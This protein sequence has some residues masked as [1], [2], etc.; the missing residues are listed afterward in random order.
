MNVE[1][2]RE[3]LEE[4]RDVCSQ[5]DA[6][7]DY[8]NY[9]G[10]PALRERMY[11]LEPTAK[12]VLAALDP[13]LADFEIDNIG[14]AA[15]ARDRA[16]KGLGLLADADEIERNLRP[17][18]PSLPADELH[19][20][21]W[22]AARTFWDAGQ[23]AVAVEQAAKSVTAHTQQKTGMSLADDDLMAQAWSD[24]PPKRD[25]PRLRFEGDRESPTWR[26]R[27]KGA[28]FLALGCYAGIRNIAAHAVSPD[29]SPQVALEALAAFSIV[30][31]WV[32]EASVVAAD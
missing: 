5:Y 16:I 19:P 12:K 9:S 3:R 32:D 15:T 26:S 18:A 7:Y 24:D 1:W 25:R 29:W 10:H 31:R 23:H 6:S 14:G 13:P 4:F 22:D 30:A 21:V 11:S 17:Q 2:M 27:Q 28:R 8:R 20:W